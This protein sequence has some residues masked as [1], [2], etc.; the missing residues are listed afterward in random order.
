MEILSIILTFL[1]FGVGLRSQV[2]LSE[3]F[4]DDT[5][6]P[7]GWIIE[8]NQGNWSR[9]YLAYAKGNDMVEAR[10]SSWPD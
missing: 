7:E 5:F 4:T 8:S 9:S 1:I 2:Y 10:L 3:N 6:P